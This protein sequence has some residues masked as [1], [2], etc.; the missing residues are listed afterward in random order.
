V[1]VWVWFSL[2]LLACVSSAPQ[3]FAVDE[4]PPQLRQLS[5]LPIDDEDAPPP[6]PRSLARKVTQPATDPYEP[7][8]L[9]LGTFTV[10]PQLEIGAIAATNARKEANGDADVGAFLKPSLSWQSDW[11]R[12][13][14]S[15][16]V[17][18][19]LTRFARD[20][21]LRADAVDATSNVRI[22]IRR[23]MILDI[24]TSYGLDLVSNDETGAADDDAQINQDLNLSL[25]LRKELGRIQTRTTL[26]LA[27]SVTGDTDAEDNGD[28][29]N[30]EP[31]LGLRVGYAT[32]GIF[33]PFIGATY[34]PR[35]FDQIVDRDGLRRSS[36]GLTTELGVAIADEPFWT[37]EV[38]LTYDFRNFTDSTLGS[39][40]AFG[41]NAALTWS[42]TELTKVTFTAGSA[43]NDGEAA[44]EATSRELNAGLSL[45]HDLR[46]NI[47]AFAGLSAEITKATDTD[48]TFGARAGVNWTFNPYLVWQATYEGTWFKSG[49]SSNENYNDQRLLTSIILRR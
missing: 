39:E 49:A 36:Q 11:P 10:K 20:N 17:S 34:A 1:R 47:Q 16:T 5:T 28:R 7:L 37:G 25:A 26:G 22:D 46:E 23:D 35:F 29:N 19:N 32:D 45:T 33:S 6:P 40:S 12:H 44:N 9:R 42:P 8:G 3:A 27:R 38:A 30:I 2:G 18:G 43:L 15:G 48:L 13:S 24:D 41:L 21:E 4:D 31:S 14:F